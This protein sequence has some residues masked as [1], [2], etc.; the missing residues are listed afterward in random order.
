MCG[1]C[2][3]I[4]FDGRAADAAAIGRMTETLS[5]RGPDSGGM[6][7]RGRVGMGHRR[8]KIIDLSARRPSSR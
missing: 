7:V 8:L 4:T 2:G 5:P 1:I 3:E 6:V